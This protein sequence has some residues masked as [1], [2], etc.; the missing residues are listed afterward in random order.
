MWRYTN[1]LWKKGIKGKEDLII[2]GN[3]G[4]KL[5]EKKANEKVEEYWSSIY[6]K[7]ENGSGEIWNEETKREFSLRMEREEVEWEDRKIE[8]EMS[9]IGNGRNDK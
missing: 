1:K 5:T 7:Y 6:R 3:E 8:I 2:Y 9:R 4:Q